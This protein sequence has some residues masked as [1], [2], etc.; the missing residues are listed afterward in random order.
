MIVKETPLKLKYFIAHALDVIFCNYIVLV[1]SVVQYY[2]LSMRTC[3]PKL[4]VLVMKVVYWLDNAIDFKVLRSSFIDRTHLNW[5]PLLHIWLNYDIKANTD[6]SFQQFCVKVSVS[7]THDDA[8]IK[9][10]RT[11][12]IG[13]CKYTI[14]TNKIYGRKTFQMDT[15]WAEKQTAKTITGHIL[16]FCFIQFSKHDA[17]RYLW[18][19]GDFTRYNW[20]YFVLGICAECN[21]EGR[22]NGLFSTRNRIYT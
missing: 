11:N 20:V 22:Y 16:R 2:W 9:W 14:I 15:E 18:R 1:W 8:V 4:R 6:I 7:F 3:E 19:V 13:F 5:R 21:D 17:F 10:I 12:G